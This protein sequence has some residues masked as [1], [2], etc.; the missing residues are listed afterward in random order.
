MHRIVDCAFSSPLA[1]IRLPRLDASYHAG[2]ST[3][4]GFTAMS[5]TAALEK[6]TRS[7]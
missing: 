2:G 3:G 6:T 4:D 1:S 5:S 7:A